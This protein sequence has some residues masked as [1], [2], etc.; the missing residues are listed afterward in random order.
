MFGKNVTCVCDHLTSF[1]IMLDY[2]NKVKPNDPSKF[3]IYVIDISLGSYNNDPN[4]HANS[5]FSLRYYHNNHVTFALNV[6]PIF[7]F[8]KHKIEFLI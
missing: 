1:G 5:K 2:S 8:D 6:K 7:F 3:D 4:L